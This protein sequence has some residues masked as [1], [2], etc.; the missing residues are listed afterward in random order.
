[1]RK[2]TFLTAS[3]F[4][5]SMCCSSVVNADTIE[6]YGSKAG[7]CRPCKGR[8]DQVCKRIYQDDDREKFQGN[9]TGEKASGFLAP[10]AIEPSETVTVE[11]DG[12]QYVIPADAI[13]WADGSI[14]ESKL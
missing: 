10:A 7:L 11:Y 14:D 1:M 4:V 2:N 9:T 13:N 3:I 8:V 12:I 6:Y 5:L